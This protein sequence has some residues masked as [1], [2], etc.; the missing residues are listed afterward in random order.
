[1][2]A[3]QEG[4]FDISDDLLLIKEFLLYGANFA[5]EVICT[6]VLPSDKLFIFM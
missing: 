4:L 6:E 3:K 5:T 2:L 1:M